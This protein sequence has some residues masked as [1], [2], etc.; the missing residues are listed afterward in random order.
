MYVVVQHRITDPAAFWSKAEELVPNLPNDLKLH[1]CVPSPD[2][3]LGICVWEG[4]SVNA[5]QRYLEGHMSKFSNN[6][7]F[8][9]E[10]KD[11]IG[12]PSKVGAATA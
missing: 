11:G 6:V 10:N 2:G 4:G 7:Y 12:L 3:K 5:V 1:H 9:G 8:E